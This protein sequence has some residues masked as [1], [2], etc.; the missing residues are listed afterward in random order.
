MLANTALQTAGVYPKTVTYVSVPFPEMATALAE[1]KVDAISAVEPFITSAGCQGRPARHVHLHR[2]DRQFPD[3]GVFRPPV[4]GAEAPQHGAR[5]PGRDG[6]GTGPGRRQPGG[7]GAD[8][9]H[10]IKSLNPDQSAVVN[11]GQFPTSLN[12][13]HLNRV[14]SLMQA[15]GLVGANFSVAPLLFH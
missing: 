9:A 4:V 10:H 15:E 14:V 13:T 11:L 2:A 5:V 7:C 8:P 6:E 3:L 12:E 1:H